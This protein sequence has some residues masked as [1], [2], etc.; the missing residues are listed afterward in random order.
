MKII[1]LFGPANT[2]KSTTIHMLCSRMMKDG[3]HEMMREGKK[4]ITAMYSKNGKRIGI[5]S[6]GDTK[7]ILEEV[8][9]ILESNKCDV[10]IC[11]C[12]TKGGTIDFLGEYGINVTYIEKTRTTPSRFDRVNR[13]DMNMIY[14][15]Y[16]TGE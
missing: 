6:Y 11:A 12:R 4:D 9:Q 3:Y 7:P 5:T 2:G 16:I 8:F 10:I 1:A 15:H 13:D 14:D